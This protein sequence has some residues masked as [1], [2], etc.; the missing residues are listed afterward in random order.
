L[1]CVLPEEDVRRF[2][3]IFV[4]ENCQGLV[5]QRR[6]RPQLLEVAS[7]LDNGLRSVPAGGRSCQKFAREEQWLAVDGLGHG[8]L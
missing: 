7:E 6:D 2:P 1:Y 5:T 4:Y 8:F 3:Q